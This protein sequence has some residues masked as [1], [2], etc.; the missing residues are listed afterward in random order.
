MPI[1]EVAALR[2]VGLWDTPPAIWPPYAVISKS[3]SA[4]SCLNDSGD[5]T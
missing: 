5:G 1:D 3:L 4:P 2:L